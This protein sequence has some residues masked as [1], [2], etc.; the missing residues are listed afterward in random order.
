[1][2]IVDIARLFLFVRE[3]PQNKGARVNG[4]QLWSLGQSG[5]SWCCEFASMMLDLAYQG[6]APIPRT[7]SCEVVRQIAETKG[8]MV[9]TPSVGDLVLS[10]NSAGVAHHI[11][12]CTGTPLTTIAGNTS[13]DGLSENGNGVYE[14]PVDPTHKLFVHLPPQ[15]LT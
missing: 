12:I 7:G 3:V 14:H 2:T 4:I 5:D 9:E 8:F 11:G 15:S 10:I 1:M 6:N 13:P